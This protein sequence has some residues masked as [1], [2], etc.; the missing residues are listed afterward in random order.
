MLS[1]ENTP[2]SSTSAL[3]NSTIDTFGHYGFENIQD[4]VLEPK[5]Q[6]KL[7]ILRDVP[8]ILP[9][10]RKLIT[11]TKSY[12]ENKANKWDSP[13][14]LYTI[15]KTR[16]KSKKASFGIHAVGTDD[17][18]AEI[19]I[20]SAINTLLKKYSIQ[21]FVLHIN[22]FGDKESKARFIRELGIYMRSIASDLPY[23]VLQD[24]KQK[25]NL[26]AL[27]RLIE[28]KHTAAYGAPDPVEFLNDDSRVR[29]REVLEY[30]EQLNINYELNPMLFGSDECW[31]HMMFDVRIPKDGGYVSIAHGGRYDTLAR[32]VYGKKLQSVGI[33]V[34]HELRGHNAIKRPCNTQPKFFISWLGDGAR[35]QAF[36][37]IDSFHDAQI[38]LA[39]SI[40][41]SHIGEQ[42]KYSERFNVPY[43]IIVGHKEMLEKTAIVRNTKT[44]VQKSIQ[45]SQLVNYVSRLKV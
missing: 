8:C 4:I 33:I 9:Q 35:A 40:K 25:H 6:D 5:D 42:I 22:S 24:V 15:D 36:S 38:P 1:L 14:L 19:T 2:Y 20:L 34:E 39:K 16:P 11:L 23:A 12:L 10:E 29:L 43:I 7:Q 30:M 17:T 44:R 31:D 41:D 13:K 26:I 3:L 18:I 21:D 28:Q 37:I 27:T 45:L 32:R